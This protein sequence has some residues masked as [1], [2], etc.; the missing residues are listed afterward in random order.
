MTNSEDLIDG[1][2]PENSTGT[3]SDDG[4]RARRGRNRDAVVEA[5]LELFSDGNL[6]PSSDEIATR[7]GLSPRSLFRYFDD[8]DDLCRAAIDR[9]Q[10]RVLPLTTISVALDASTGQRIEALVGQRARVFDAIGSVGHVSRLRAPFQPLVNAQLTLAR[11]FFREQIKRLMAPELTAMGPARAAHAVAAV[12]VLCSFE[13]Y[14]LFRHDQMLSRASTMA[15]LV[16]TLTAVF[17]GA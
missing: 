13:A 15:A 5:M 7:A 8:I 9:Q 17:A 6:A 16:D 11:V 1:A 12:D 10:Q 2:R 3:D 14:Q 4:R